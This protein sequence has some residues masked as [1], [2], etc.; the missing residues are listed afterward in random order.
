MG[1]FMNSRD[2]SEH[3]ELVTTP[4]NWRRGRDE[5]S[6]AAVHRLSASK[7]EAVLDARFYG[8]VIERCLAV[9]EACPFTRWWECEIWLDELRG[10]LDA[11]GLP[12]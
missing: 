5:E 7:I 12:W 11:R 9:G 6:E 3:A 2:P 1:G 4:L 8:S 10:A